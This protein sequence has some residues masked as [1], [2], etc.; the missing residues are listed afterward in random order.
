MK[1]K[2]T[3]VYADADGESHFED[4]EVVLE[5]VDYAPPA[6]PLYITEFGPATKVVFLGMTTDWHGEVWHPS[7]HRQLS[8]IRPGLGRLE[9]KVSDG[10][11]RIQG[12]GEVWLF[13]DTW[14]KGH[15]TR[16][17]PDEGVT[18]AWGIV[19]QLPDE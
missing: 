9:Q 15:S 16:P 11:T 12:P 17:L 3:R 5:E 10:E 4:V 8:Q 14:G 6:P 1:A 7:P 2:Y 13:E 19:I 18:E